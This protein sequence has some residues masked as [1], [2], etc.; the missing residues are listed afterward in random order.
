ML[1]PD[2]MQFIDMTGYGGPEVLTLVEGPVPRPGTGEV[3]IRVA[4]AGMNRGDILQRTGNYPPP[5]GA[6]PVLGLEVSGTIA[7]VGENVGD[8][9]EGQEVCAWSPV[10]AMPNFA[11]CRRHNASRYRAA[12]GWSRQRRCR[13]PF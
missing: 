1:V 5:P 7:A 11:P 10:A 2:H 9:R 3:L 6:S 12:S 13:R 4:A 8:L